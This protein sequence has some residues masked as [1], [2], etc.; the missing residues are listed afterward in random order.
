MNQR[1][2]IPA[3]G[4]STVAAAMLDVALPE[5]N[6]A[7][8]PTPFLLGVH[9][10]EYADMAVYRGRPIRPLGAAIAGARPA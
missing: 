10:A 6:P 9:G 3:N 1:K 4:I 7:V 5:R 2:L 8:T